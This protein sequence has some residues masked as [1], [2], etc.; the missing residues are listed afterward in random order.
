V[1]I[2]HKQRR[3]SFRFAGSGKG[4]L[5]FQCSLDGKRFASC[6]SGV[7]Y[8]HLKKGVHNFRV[9]AKAGAKVDPTPSK[10]RFRI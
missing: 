4:K 7:V 3:A 8:K 6:H 1:T 5:S 10:R 2:N 9:R